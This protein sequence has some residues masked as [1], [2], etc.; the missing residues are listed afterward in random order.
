MRYDGAALVKAY[1]PV[2][3]PGSA[4]MGDFPLDR[5]ITL[6]GV[7]DAVNEFLTGKLITNDYENGVGKPIATLPP[8][9]DLIKD[10]VAQAIRS[11][12]RFEEHELVGNHYHLTDEY[13]P[14]QRR[15]RKVTVGP[16]TDPSW[17]YQDITFLQGTALAYV[18]ALE[19][20]PR[21]SDNSLQNIA[22]AFKGMAHFVFDKENVEGIFKELSKKFQPDRHSPALH[23]VELPACAG[24][25]K[26]AWLTGRYEFSTTVMDMEQGWDYFYHQAQVWMG[27][28]S[29]DV[30]CHGKAVVDGVTFKCTFR[31]EE[32]A[33]K[34]AAKFFEDS[35]LYGL[36]PNAY[37]A[38]DYIPFSFVVD[39][40]V[41]IGDSLSAY[42]MASHF[43][44]LYYEYKQEY[45]DYSL[46][47]SLEYKFK[48]WFGECQVYCR[49]YESA[50]PQVEASYVLLAP[51]Q[52]A[53]VKTR[54]FRCLDGL[55]L[56]S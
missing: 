29:S 4:T 49:W 31:M 42:T 32:K 8:N 34:G 51:R 11:G 19:D 35:Y 47:Y 25:A 37:T 43:T 13:D 56:L 33:L 54:V 39:W 14:F 7:M 15:H 28:E 41:P 38:W 30:K 50:P 52:D 22:A 46:C 55:A 40:F 48:A 44:P 16:L 18:K 26:D 1:R 23:R 24:A 6:E 3:K 9:A 53:K 20:F 17:V 5:E 21:F 45:G 36:E 10:K 12:C 2:L 27:T